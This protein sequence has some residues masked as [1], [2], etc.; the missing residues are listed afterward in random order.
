MILNSLLTLCCLY[1][2]NS[3]SLTLMS[4]VPPRNHELNNLILRYVKAFEFAARDVT[5]TTTELEQS[6]DAR[7]WNTGMYASTRHQLNP[8]GRSSTR[9]IAILKP[10]QLTDNVDL[11]EPEDAP[12]PDLK[13]SVSGSPRAHHP[14]RSTCRHPTRLDFA[15]M[16]PE[17]RNVHDAR[18]ESNL[19]SNQLFSQTMTLRQHYP[20]LITNLSRT[21]STMLPAMNPGLTTVTLLVGPDGTLYVSVPGGSTTPLSAYIGAAAS[22][23]PFNLGPTRTGLFG[24]QYVPS[25]ADPPMQPTGTAPTAP[26]LLA[27]APAAT[28][29]PA[30]QQPKK[31]KAPE[32]APRTPSPVPSKTEEVD[33][34]PKSPDETT[35]NYS[36]T[37][38]LASLKSKA[39]S[40]KKDLND[41]VK[42][43]KDTTGE[44]PDSTAVILMFYT[45]YSHNC[46]RCRNSTS[47][48]RKKM[49]TDFKNWF[50]QYFNSSL[51]N[52]EIKEIHENTK[53]F[54]SGKLKLD[55][56]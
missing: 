30:D 28:S 49:R 3:E 35:K 21:N 10:F 37:R 14:K 24:P 11:R 44:A 34:K 17:P 31:K 50:I 16:K 9:P 22:G 56:L 36:Q 53:G 47:E 29:S 15:K 41:R 4:P 48:H 54:E 18:N 25:F 38:G 40:L 51:S 52:D 1:F 19:Q 33:V 23:G 12:L 45:I 20:L 13:E 8:L 43:H 6:L 46:T 2:G 32:P 39:A 26:T 27:P 7:E 55:S 5:S 42:Q